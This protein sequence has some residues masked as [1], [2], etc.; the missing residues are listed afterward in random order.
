MHLRRLVPLV[1]TL[2]GEIDP[3]SSIEGTV[4]ELCPAAGAA[5]SEAPRT[6]A[7]SAMERRTGM[8]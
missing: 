5:S 6:M 1:S 8:A 2:A 4:A 3:L 7:T